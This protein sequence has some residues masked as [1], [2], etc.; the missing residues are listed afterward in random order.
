MLG[1]EVGNR[2][3]VWHF[4]THLGDCRIPSR[5]SPSDYPGQLITV[6]KV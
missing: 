2:Y 4:G 1:Q 3:S 6:A 5:K